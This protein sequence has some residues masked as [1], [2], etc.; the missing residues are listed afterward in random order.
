M[1]WDAVGAIGEI[2]GAFAV[3]ATL[4]YLAIQVRYAKS[5]AADTNRLMR[6][7]GVRE[8]ALALAQNDNLRRSMLKGLDLEA[9][10]RA[11]GDSLN[12]EAIDAERWDYVCQYYFWLHWGQYSTTSTQED[13]DELKRLIASF[14]TLPVIKYHWN[15][16]PFGKVF[17]DD[18]FVKFVDSAIEE[19]DAP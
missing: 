8:M 3:V 11:V 1:N 17:F 7:A 14:Y 12:I 13:I 18:D 2:V 19:S 9:H 16:S 15:N 4:A 6:A 10:F 5:T